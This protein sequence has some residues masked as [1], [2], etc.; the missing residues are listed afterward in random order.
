MIFIFSLES[1]QKEKRE[2]KKRDMNQ[3]NVRSV[4]FITR[5]TSKSSS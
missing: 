1:D 4:L 5:R 2:E 3:Q